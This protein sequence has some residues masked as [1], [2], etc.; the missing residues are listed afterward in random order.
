MRFEYRLNQH[1]LIVILFERLLRLSSF[2]KFHLFSF[3][4]S[5]LAENSW[6]T[7]LML[8]ARF[9]RT[10]GW[11]WEFHHVYITLVCEEQSFL[12]TS[13][14][15]GYRQPT[16]YLDFSWFGIMPE[17]ASCSIL[18]GCALSETIMTQAAFFRPPICSKFHF[19]PLFETFICLC[20]AHDICGLD[21][22]VT[23]LA[24]LPSAFKVRF[25][26][27]WTSISSF[28]QS[29]WTLFMMY[30]RCVLI[31]KFFVYWR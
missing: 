16:I 4:I 23:Y 31:V 15:S 13:I 26:L 22:L 24:S 20:A 11:C 28:S 18:I 29:F 3:Q 12:H 25:L 8:R 9:W 30:F 14:S 21:C 2:Q 17:D 1:G 19:H 6:E 10:E 7:L 27:H 5:W